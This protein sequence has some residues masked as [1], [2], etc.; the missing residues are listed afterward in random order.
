MLELKSFREVI[1]NLVEDDNKTLDYF[2]DI[3]YDISELLVNYRIEHNMTQKQLAKVL[4]VSQVMISKY[5][6]GN[7][8]FT[9][10]K[11]CEICEALGYKPDVAFNSIGISE[12]NE[13]WTAQGKID[14]QE[15]MEEEPSCEELIA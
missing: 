5:E 14:L 2:F 3:N 11:I 10:M 8:N 6:N 15:T 13:K 7:Y 9:L 4:D 1:D 12:S